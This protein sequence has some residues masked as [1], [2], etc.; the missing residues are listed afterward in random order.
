MECRGQG[1]VAEVIS[2]PI[3]VL[4]FETTGLSPLSARVTEVAAIKIVDGQVTD[5][6][7]T[8]INCGVAV[9]AEITSFTGISTA[10]VR[11]APQVSEVMPALHRFVGRHAIVAHNAHF[12]QGFYEQE[13]RRLKL[14]SFSEDFICTI[15]VARRVVPGLSTYKLSALSAHCGVTFSSAAHRAEAD[16][17]VTGE[18]LTNL[19]GRILRSGVPRVSARFLRELMTCRIADAG[20]MMRREAKW[21]WEEGKIQA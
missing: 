17:L 12:D 2:E 3:I 1:S 9:P 5:R 20:E 8:L 21:G 11:A 6:F 19:S 4:D 16:A 14:T 13:L 15:R 10:M 7:V 18:V